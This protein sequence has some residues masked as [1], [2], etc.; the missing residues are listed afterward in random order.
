MKGSDNYIRITDQTSEY[1]DGTPVNHQEW[2]ITE[3]SFFPVDM[4]VTREGT[5][6]T[7]YIIHHELEQ[8]YDPLFNAT[9]IV[10]TLP[11][12]LTAEQLLE[13]FRIIKDNRTANCT[14]IPSS[15]KKQKHDACECYKLPTAKYATTC[16]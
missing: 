12:P 9:D 10:T 3:Q 8:H 5:T 6:E 13:K 4:H 1:P 11:T 14:V 2:W 7:V 15:N 16:E